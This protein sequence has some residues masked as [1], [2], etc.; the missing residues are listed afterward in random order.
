MLEEEKD[1]FAMDVQ[2]IFEMQSD[3]KK[4]IEDM[5]KHLGIPA[6]IENDEH[7]LNQLVEHSVDER[8]FSM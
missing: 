4:V 6:D 5:E 8:R 7:A 3:M 1:R 2:M